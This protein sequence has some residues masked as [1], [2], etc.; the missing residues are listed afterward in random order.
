MQKS[1]RRTIELNFFVIDISW[2]I[3]ISNVEYE[4]TR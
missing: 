4:F 1:L 3:Y 2:G